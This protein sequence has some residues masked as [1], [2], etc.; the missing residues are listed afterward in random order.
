MRKLLKRKIAE[1]N[2]TCAICL[3]EF[4]NYSY[5]VP[6]HREPKGMGGARGMITRKISKPHIGGVIQTKDQR[7]WTSDGRLT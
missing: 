7:G 5:V 2:R 6:D 3:E 4:T 1:Q